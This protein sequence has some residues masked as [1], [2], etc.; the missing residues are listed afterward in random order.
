MIFKPFGFAAG[1]DVGFAFVVAAGFVCF[2]GFAGSNCP[3][4]NAAENKIFAL[5]KSI[6]L[7]N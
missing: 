7:T 1:V 3:L 5:K 2:T 6:F 4:T